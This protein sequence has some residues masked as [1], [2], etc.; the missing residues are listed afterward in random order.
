MNQSTINKLYQTFSVLIFICLFSILLCSCQKE[1]SSPSILIKGLSPGQEI[2]VG[3]NILIYASASD[4]DGHVESISLIINDAIVRTVNSDTLKYSW[5]VKGD[6]GSSCQIRVIAFNNHENLSEKTFSILIVQPPKLPI[7][8]FYAHHTYFIPGTDIHFFDRSE[9]NPSSWLWDFGDG[10]ISS[11]RN[12]IHRYIN[13]GMY[14]VC[15]HVLNLMGSDSLLK[16]NYIVVGYESDS[17]VKDYDGHIYRTVKIGNQI[18]TAENLKSTFYSDGSPVFNGKDVGSIG[19][20]TT[21]R[22]YFSY[23]NDDFNISHYGRLY[24]WPAAM[25]SSRTSNEVPSGVQGIC[26]SG[27]HLPSD[28]EWME[29]EMFLGMSKEEVQKNEMRGVNEGGKLKVK[30]NN[31]WRAPNSEATN[32]YGFSAYPGGDRFWIGNY[33]HKEEQASFWTSTEFNYITSWRR[34]LKSEHGGISRNFFHRK[35]VGLSVRCVK[36]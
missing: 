34:I 17:T 23:D 21:S 30:G 31:F 12:P 27:W 26:P 18:W 16:E 8:K 4:I 10:N 32:E 19:W 7:A 33:H 36:D 20:D 29:L 35:S 6:Y 25:N 3:S 9:Y 2:E 22:Y 5:E 15:L 14:S 28:R 1:Y 13:P 24:T 11:E